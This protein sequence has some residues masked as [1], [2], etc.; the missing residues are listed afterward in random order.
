MLSNRLSLVWLSL[1]LGL[2]PHLSFAQTT[3]NCCFEHPSVG[4]DDAACEA[5]VCTSTRS[6]AR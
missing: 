6:A 2:S 5:T 3:S 4:C 1:L